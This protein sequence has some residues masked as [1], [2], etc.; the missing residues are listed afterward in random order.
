MDIQ[1]RTYE[2]GD[3]A[4]LADAF[5]LPFQGLGGG[6]LRTPA[7]VRWRYVSRPGADPREIQV[8]VDKDS[9][10]IAGAVYSTIETY[11]FAG[12]PCRTGAINDVGT[13]P[14]YL[15]RG[16][17]R[18][19]MAQAMD[20]MKSARCEYSV[21]SADT[22]GFPRE[23]L[24]LPA[25]YQDYFRESVWISIIDPGT[26]S[27][28]VPLMLPA[29]PALW[30]SFATR[31]LR[32]H[33]IAKTLADQGIAATIPVPVHGGGLDL[34]V[35]REIWRFH[36]AVAPRQMD[37]YTRF[38]L[39]DWIYFR[40]K[41][42][43]HDMLPVYAILRD[44]KKLIGYANFIRQW[45]YISGTRVRFPFAFIREVLVDHSAFDDAWMLAAAYALLAG[46]IWQAAAKNRCLALL[47]FTSPKYA[48]LARALKALGFFHA[49]DGTFMVN[50]LSGQG[51]T[52]PP[53][54]RPFHVNPGEN[55][56][57]P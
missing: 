11:Q 51:S 52:L 31:R 37:G 38:P 26:A 15:G 13:L 28:L 29:I 32:V 25:G 49:Q 44:G 47:C 46:T 50:P 18:K 9:G 54:R 40:E 20:F 30:I 43:T 24:Y 33:R 21:L 56:A 55:F 36:E 27:V 19:L 41:P 48:C 5:N 2:P 34:H 17:G 35:S 42:M 4:G 1:Y 12:V 22:H 45:I 3:E 14:A 16:I 23:R 39:D 8:A 57:Y 10:K 7:R 6:F 53:L